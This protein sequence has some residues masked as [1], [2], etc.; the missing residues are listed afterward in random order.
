MNRNCGNIKDGVDLKPSTRSTTKIENRWTWLYELVFI[1]YLKQ[2]FSADNGYGWSVI[3]QKEKMGKDINLSFL[4]EQKRKENL[5]C[6]ASNIAKA[7]SFSVKEIRCSC[8]THLWPL[9]LFLLRWKNP[10]AKTLNPKIKIKK[11]LKLII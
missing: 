2:L 1:L 6:R 10:L 7:L 11:I 5:K 4:K 9:A 8:P 3:Q